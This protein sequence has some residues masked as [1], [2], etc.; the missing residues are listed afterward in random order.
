M[1]GGEIFLRENDGF[2]LPEAIVVIAIMIILIT[3]FLA[4]FKPATQVNKANDAK[5]KDHLSRF[6]IAFEDY[7][8]DYNC[9]PNFSLDCGSTALSPYLE[10][11]YCDP[12][13]GP[14]AYIPATPE[15]CPQ[16]FRIYTTLKNSSD[17]DISKVGCSNGCGPGGSPTYKYCVSSTNVTCESTLVPN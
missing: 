2:S 12:D 1:A 17:L 9:Y 15:N 7:Y 8:G 14:Y 11:I 5:K 4:S 6:K 16:S 13:G 10:K 3:S